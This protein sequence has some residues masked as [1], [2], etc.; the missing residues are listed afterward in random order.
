MKKLLYLLLFVVSTTRA[1]TPVFVS[2]NGSDSIARA[3]TSLGA[4][5]GH[6]VLSCGTFSYSTALQITK[7]NTILS[8]SGAGSEG[9]YAS[10]TT[11][12]P[13]AGVDGID[14]T[15][16]NVTVEYLKIDSASTSATA[17]IGIHVAGANANYPKIHNVSINHTGSHCIYLDSF[18][19][20]LVNFAQLAHIVCSNSWGG[21]AYRLDGN[22]NTNAGEFHDLVAIGNAGWCLNIAPTG[23]GVV[24]NRFYGM[25]C[26]AN[27]RGAYHFGPTAVDNLLDEPYT[28][29][30]VGA[31]LLI[32]PG[33][34][35]N[36]MNLPFNNTPTITDFA[37]WA[38]NNKITRYDGPHNAQGVYG[39]GIAPSPAATPQVFWTMH[40]GVLGPGALDLTDSLSNNQAM[41]CQHAATNP[42]A[43][44]GTN[45][46]P[47]YNPTSTT[48]SSLPAA[49]AGNQG[50]IKTV[51]DSTAIT[52]EGQACVGSGASTA[53]AFS[54]GSTWKCF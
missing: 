9:T 35:A 25:N 10:C 18:G 52:V 43:F 8:G 20:N 6:I 2:A 32:D 1:Q 5:G 28:E 3:L 42:C 37:G 11:L 14:I 16:Q 19:V 54:D 50:W 24:N 44:S 45:S 12:R 26:V 36:V 41:V 15:A 13:A 47:A 31:T 39:F 53:L 4:N 48:V 23:N 22:V 49:A 17:D 46:A 38:F 30:G 34:A 33:A 40:S 7:P 21:D 29:P 27:A 51:S